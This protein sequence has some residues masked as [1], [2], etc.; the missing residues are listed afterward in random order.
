MDDL[1]GG[2]WGD[3]RRHDGGRSVM[4]G[5]DGH[6]RWQFDAGTI[7]MG[8]GE[9]SSHEPEPSVIPNVSQGAWLTVILGGGSVFP[10][11]LIYCRHG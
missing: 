4:D 9:E 6:R 11:V 10:V 3:R 8:H 2:G 1:R 7:V 5:D